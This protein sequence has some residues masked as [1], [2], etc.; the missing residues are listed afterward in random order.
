ME[1]S[2][3]EESCVNL[4]GARGTR[5]RKLLPLGNRASVDVLLR[6]FGFELRSETRVS[7]RVLVY[8]VGS[9]GGLSEIRE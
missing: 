1:T 4:V 3:H 2:D 9:C 5:V 6:S 8:R 7:N